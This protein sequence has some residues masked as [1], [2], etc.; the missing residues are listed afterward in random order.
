[1]EHMSIRWL[2][3]TEEWYS[4]GAADILSEGMMVGM[5]YREYIG[6]IDVIFDG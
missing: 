5:L 6:L 2:K 3:G 4:G 1:M